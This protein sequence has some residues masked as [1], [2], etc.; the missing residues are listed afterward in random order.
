MLT[1]FLLRLERQGSAQS[2]AF[3][4][5]VTHVVFLQ[6]LFN[7][8]WTRDT[9]LLVTQFT[10]VLLQFSQ[11]L[12]RV[13]VAHG[14]AELH[15]CLRRYPLH[16]RVD[17][18]RRLRVASRRTMDRCH[19]TVHRTWSNMSEISADIQIDSLSG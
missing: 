4:S 10:E 14:A 3:L 8:F 16:T 5:T 15:S 17:S 2:N 13:S 1:T 7:L 11:I 18:I 6:E 19:W 9:L 12:N